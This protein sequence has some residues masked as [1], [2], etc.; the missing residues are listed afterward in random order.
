MHMKTS[1]RNNFQGKVLSVRNGAVNDEIEVMLDGSGTRITAV[2]TS[3][4]AKNLGLEAG[5]TVFAL[6]KASWVILLTDTGGVR[7]SARNQL[8]GTVLSVE[9][10]AVNCEVRVRLEGG[11]ALTA[12]ITEESAKNLGLKPGDKVTALI[13]ASHVILGVPA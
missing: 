2:I 4:S 10:G 1:A 9:N 7:F 6:I 11:E 8:P 13:K 5:K 12:I 3:A